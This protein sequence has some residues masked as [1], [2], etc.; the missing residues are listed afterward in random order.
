MRRSI[1][2]RLIRWKQSPLRK[3]LLLTGVRQCGKTY[4]LR[5]FGE[6]H[7][8][9]TAYLNL[10][11]NHRIAAVFEEDLDP[12]RI[13]K[14]LETLFLTKPVRLG[15]TLLIL[16]EIQT[17]PR[18]ITALK[19]FQEDIPNLHVIGAGSLLGVS[20]RRQEASFPVG[21]VDR[22][23]MYPLS[24]QEYLWANGQQPLEESLWRHDL[25]QPLGAHYAAPLKRTLLEYYVVGGMPEAV[26]L[27]AAHKD[28]EAVTQAQQ[29]ILAGYAGDFSKYA[30]P[31]EFTNLEAIWRSIPVQ[32]A[33]DNSKFVFSRAKASARAKDLEGAMQWLVDAGLFHL[34]H[35]VEHAIAPL[36]PQADRTYYKVYL[37]DPGLLC[38]M[39]GLS[40]ASVLDE[41]APP[42]ALKGAL[43]E[44]FVL[45][46][47]IFQQYQ[48]FYWRSGN[49]AELDFLIEQAGHVI[50]IEAKANLNTQAKSYREFARRFKPALGFKLSMKNLG[51]NQVLQTNT[52]S[53]PL[54]VI[55]QLRTIIKQS[56]ALNQ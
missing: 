15:S 42:H 53:L 25:T 36:S 10:E 30:P 33:R 8:E 56:L 14:D 48:P 23:Q 4:T 54:Y 3:P 9:D 35:K 18:A 39:A 22:L 41:G 50:P 1:M 31:G 44:N 28:M 21:K 32:L 40:P 47:L 45:T 20:L 16:D 43:T 52:Y 27:W 37:C 17:A 11:Q 12:R 5:Q 29:N 24:F 55:G 34:L 2:E 46:Q 7:F 13:L 49:T 19:Y 6:E 38:R 26:S 51:L